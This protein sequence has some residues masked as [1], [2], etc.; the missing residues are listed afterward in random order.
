MTSIARKKGSF[1]LRAYRGDAKTLL[2]FNLTKKASKNLAGFTIR[3]KPKGKPAYYIHNFLR[4][5]SPEDHA[6][7]ANESPNSSI[8]APIHKFRWIHVPGQVHQGTTPFLGDY[9]Y[10]VTPRYFDG[11]HSLKALDTALSVSVTIPVGGFSKKNVALGFARG[12]VQ[13][14]AFVNHFGPKALVRP[15]DKKLQ[16]DTSRVAGTNAAGQQYTYREQYDWLGFTAR[17]KVLTLLNEVLSNKNLLVDVFAYDLNEPDVVNILLKLAKKGRVRAIL[18]NAGLH[19]SKA[20]PKPEDKFATLFAKAAG[21]ESLLLR[22]KF[23]RYAH[24]K[25]FIVYRKGKQKN[26]PLKVLT[27]STN[28]SVTGLYVNSNHVL[29]YNDKQVAGWYAGV[30][31]ESWR[32]QVKKSPFIKSDWSKKTFST[33][34]KGAPKTDITFSP[35]DRPGANRNDKKEAAKVL[36]VVVDRIA[37][38]GKKGKTVGSILFAVMAIDKGVSPAGWFLSTTDHWTTPY[39]DTRDLHAIDRQLFA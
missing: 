19:H 11:N 15:K 25:V 1:S 26:I 2:A 39:F 31:E 20:K 37:A 12:Y 34:T 23:G 13:S 18:D 30:F 33:T 27:G 10:T 29:V 35:H 14:Q 16:F 5:K 8:N 32:D 3:C 6:Q 4:F 36:K 17:E 9:R 24:D 7:D 38:E 28:F 21:K 22:G